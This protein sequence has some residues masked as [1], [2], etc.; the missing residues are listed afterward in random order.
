MGDYVKDVNG[1]ARSRSGYVPLRSKPERGMRVKVRNGART[2]YGTVDDVSA[3]GVAW[4]EDGGFL[5]QLGADEFFILVDDTECSCEHA[6]EWVP[7]TREQVA[8]LPAR[9][10]VRVEDDAVYA[11]PEDVPD[12]RQ[13]ARA[14]LAVFRGEQA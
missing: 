9:T 8:L 10:V 5:G 2:I 14:G 12:Y 7:L 3:T 1:E 11:H 4:A 6:P 13:I